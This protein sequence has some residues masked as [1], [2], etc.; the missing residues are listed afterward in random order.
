MNRP[1]MLA[2]LFALIAS[3]VLGPGSAHSSDIDMQLRLRTRIQPYHESGPWVQA[4]FEDS[5][6]Y[7]RTAIVIAQ[8]TLARGWL[9]E[10]FGSLIMKK[11]KSS[12]L[13]LL[14]VCQK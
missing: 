4:H 13:P 2:S 14:M 12:R 6:V 3:T 11:L 8:S 1:R 5:I 7:D 10:V 9:G